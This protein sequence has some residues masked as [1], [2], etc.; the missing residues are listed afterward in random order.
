MQQKLHSLAAWLARHS[1]HKHSQALFS[2]S[3]AGGE[4][5][6]SGIASAAATCL[7]AVGTA[8]QL[9]QLS[10]DVRPAAHAHACA[11]PA[12]PCL[13]S[14]SRWRRRAS[15]CWVTSTSSISSEHAAV[16]LLNTHAAVFI[17]RLSL[18]VFCMV[19]LAKL[20]WHALEGMSYQEARTGRCINEQVQAEGR[21]ATGRMYT[22]KASVQQ[23][24]AEARAEGGLSTRRDT[25][26]QII[27]GGRMKTCTEV[28]R[29]GGT[30]P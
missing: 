23:T 21:P 12:L 29:L 27:A 1:P 26:A 4:G 7:T 20:G 2:R 17:S 25:Y 16:P 6:D 13:R 18:T 22:Q 5:V 15:S 11:A 10:I 30:A 19:M 8:G 28:P 14:A 9:T 24:I 3:A